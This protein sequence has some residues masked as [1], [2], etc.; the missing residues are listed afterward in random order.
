[1]SLRCPEI[2]GRSDNLHATNP[3]GWFWVVQPH[4][5]RNSEREREREREKGREASLPY[6]RRN[7]CAR[8]MTNRVH[9][10]RGG[11]AARGYDRALQLLGILEHPFPD[12]HWGTHGKRTSNGWRHGGQ[13]WR[14]S[15]EAWI[16]HT[17]GDSRRRQAQVRQPG[18]D[19]DEPD[20][21]SFMQ[22]ARPSRPPQRRG[23]TA[24]PSHEAEAHPHRTQPQPQP[25]ARTQHSQSRT[26]PQ[27]PQARRGRQPSRWTPKPPRSLGIHPPSAASRIGGHQNPRASQEPNPQST[28][29]SQ[30]PSNSLQRSWSVETE[31]AQIRPPAQGGRPTATGGAT[32]GGRAAA[33]EEHIQEAMALVAS[34]GCG[35]YT[36]GGRPDQPAAGRP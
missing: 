7:A 15:S 1:M 3:P 32:G 12:Q 17:G 28:Q 4:R 20:E 23:A 21:Q 27:R 31:A 35:P 30:S 34:P 8:Q 25:R 6:T 11:Q 13:S 22:Q 2:T 24:E 19:R 5:K 16:S 9:W 26:T 29:N 33:A 36:P 14:G 18:R 10:P